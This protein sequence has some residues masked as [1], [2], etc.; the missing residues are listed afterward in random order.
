[1]PLVS[2][3]KPS[4]AEGVIARGVPPYVGAVERFAFLLR[5]SGFDARAVD[6]Q[7][8]IVDA[9]DLVLSTLE[10]CAHILRR[11]ME[12]STHGGA[13]WVRLVEE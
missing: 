9:D 10:A 7:I 2:Q 13:V 1:M 5:W 4:F 8:R 3:S 11:R 12:T 6:G